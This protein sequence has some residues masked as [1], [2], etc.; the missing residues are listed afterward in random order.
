MYLNGINT[1]KIL[2]KNGT[3]ILMKNLIEEN[4]GFGIII[5]IPLFIL[6]ALTI[7]TCSG[8]RLMLGHQ[9]LEKQIDYSL[10]S[11]KLVKQIQ[12]AMVCVTLK[13][14]DQDSLLWPQERL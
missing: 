12:D 14:V 3:T 9:I 4:R 11:G 2:K 6:L 7:C 13:T 5:K 1:L 10:Y 8:V